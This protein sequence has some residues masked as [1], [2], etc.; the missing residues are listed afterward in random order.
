MFQKSNNA[1]QKRVVFFIRCSLIFRVKSMRN[2]AKKHARR[3]SAQKSTKNNVSNALLNQKIDFLSIFE[4]PLGPRGPP[5]TSQEPSRIRH[6]FHASSVVSENQPGGLPGRPQGG[7]GRHPGIPQGT[8]L[9]R[10]GIDVAHQKI[11]NECLKIIQNLSEK[12]L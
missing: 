5:R 6:F 8:I 4:I 7:P 10:F 2:R 11:S 3:S 12:K 9:D 1:M